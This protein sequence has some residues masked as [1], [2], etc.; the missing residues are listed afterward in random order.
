ML[1][2]HDCPTKKSA[3]VNLTFKRFAAAITAACRRAGITPLAF[4]MATVDCF[5]FAASAKAFC[6]ANLEITCSAWFI[7]TRVNHAA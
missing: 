5:T 2:L 6:V 1:D 4:H 3:G 7:K